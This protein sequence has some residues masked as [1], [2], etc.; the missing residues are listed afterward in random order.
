[1]KREGS[2]VCQ[3]PWFR[4][5]WAKV[6]LACLP[7]AREPDMGEPPLFFEPCAAR[8]VEAPLMRQEPFVP[9]G[10]EH[11]VE[12]EPLGGMKRHQVDAVGAFLGLRVHD[13][14]HMLEEAR[15]RVELLHEAD[16][17]FQVLELRLRLRRALGLPH[18]G[19]AGLIEDQLG[20]LGM[21]HRVD[22]RAPAVEGSD[23]VGKRLARLGLE[24]LGLDDQP[25]RLEQ[26]HPLRARQL[27]HGLEARFAE[28]PP[29][30]VE[31]ALEFEVV[32]RIERHLEIG[33]RVPD[34]LALVE[35]GPADDAIGEPKGD[36][37]V[38]EGAHLE[39]GADEDR[40]RAQR[41]TLPLLLLDILADDARF[42]LVVPAALDLDLVA[43]R[44]VGAERLAETP[45]VVGDQPRGR[46]EDMPG[47]A[48]IALEPDDLGAGEVGLEPQDV[49]DL[50]AAPAI[51]RLVVV[52]DAADVAVAL[53][54]Q[55]EPQI[56]GDVR[57]PD[58]RPPA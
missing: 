11:G 4:R 32:R 19:I 40:D 23:Q 55:P 10:E 7:R 54:E 30:R 1:M 14:A 50:G 24:L 18:A 49:V 16:Q 25:R 56:L 42:L 45:L 39:R 8:F 20:E 15:E 21:P 9:A 2:A 26:R 17:L 34:L 41:V 6:I 5:F 37:A 29:R 57:S 51:D 31:D 36:E 33:G 53:R 43:E 48:V 13:Q 46:A 28:T 22:Q 27:M 3:V 38:L 47:R 58:I 35:A 12:F 52:A 44:A